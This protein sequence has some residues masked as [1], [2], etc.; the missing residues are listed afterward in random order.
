MTDKIEKETEKEI[1]KEAEKETE[2]KIGKE[3]EKEIEKKI[4]KEIVKEMKQEMKKSE[5]QPESGE[6]SK[7]IGTPCGAVRGTVSAKGDCIVYKGIRYANAKRFQYPE[8]V[9]HWDGI[10]EADRFGNCSYQPRAFYDEA[11]VPEKAFYYHEFREGE[12]YTYSEDCLFLN[13]WAPLEAENAPV[14]FYIH[15]GG[16]K[17]GCGHEKH[18]DGAAYCRQGIL[19]VTTAWDLLDLPAWRS[20]RMRRGMP[21]ITPCTTRWRPYHGSAA[22][23]PRLA[24]IR[25]GSP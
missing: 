23:S 21:A 9:T 4:R 22:I 5:I 20:G 7:M 1:G 10:Y 15:G 11:K 25:T 2:K 6:S 18:F 19:V 3:A 17:G 13:I 14:L 24:A 8:E 12:S 16:F